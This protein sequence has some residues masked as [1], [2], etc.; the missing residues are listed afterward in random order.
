MDDKGDDVEYQQCGLVKDKPHDGDGGGVRDDDALTLHR[1]DLHDLTSA[2]P[3]GNVGI[4][5][6]DK[7]GRYTLMDFV[8]TGIKTAE[9]EDDE[10]I[11][12]VGNDDDSKHRHQINPIGFGE[13]LD[14]EGKVRVFDIADFR[15][16][17]KG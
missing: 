13:S 16:T 7:G 2:S 17:G 10:T 9:N 14:D 15:S 12:Y 3:R 1:V 4:E 11:D 5:L 6:S 8:P